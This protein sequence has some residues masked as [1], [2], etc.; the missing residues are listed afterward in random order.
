MSNQD[1][2]RVFCLDLEEAVTMG[3]FDNYIEKEEKVE[4]E[5]EDIPSGTGYGN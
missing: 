3:E 1:I 4:P 5:V 2:E